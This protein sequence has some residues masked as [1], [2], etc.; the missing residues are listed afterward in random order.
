MKPAADTLF[1]A[2]QANQPCLLIV[3]KA[4]MHILPFFGRFVATC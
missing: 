4:I 3:G 1:A 2:V